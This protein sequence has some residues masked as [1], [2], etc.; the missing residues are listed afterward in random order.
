MRS[1]ASFCDDPTNRV[2]RY[3]SAIAT[4]IRVAAGACWVKIGRKCWI[5]RIRVPRNPWDI[6]VGDMA[7]LVDDVVLPLACVQMYRDWS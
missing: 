2:I 3:P 4:L 7:A 5:R 6:L 1:V